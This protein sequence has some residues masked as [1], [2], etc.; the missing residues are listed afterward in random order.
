MPG[1][2]APGI[3]A[4]RETIGDVP[5]RLGTGDYDPTMADRPVMALRTPLYLILAALGVL[6][7]V[8][9][10]LPWATVESVGSDVSVAGTEAGG[11]GAAAIIAGAAIAVIGVI[12]YFWN[13]FSD[14]E[15]LF[16][17]GFSLATLIAAIAKFGDT[18]SFVDPAGEFLPDANVGVGLWLILL[19]SVVALAG[20]AWI[21]VSRPKAETQL[22]D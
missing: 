7:F 21:V 9:T 2:P 6:I 13:P 11:W 12:G 22:G 5:S 17:A 15:A 20:A 3:F 14:P 10:F 16:I 19:A 18:A 8:A 4:F 1:A